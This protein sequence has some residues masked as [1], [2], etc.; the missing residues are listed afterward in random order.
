MPRSSANNPT[1]ESVCADLAKSALRFIKAKGRV[2]CGFEAVIQ[3]VDQSTIYRRRRALGIESLPNTRRPS[4]G[5]PATFHIPPQD[6][7][8]PTTTASQRHG[9]SVARLRQLRDKAGIPSDE[10]TF[11]CFAIE[12]AQYTP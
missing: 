10:Q 9:V 4:S 5:R 11:R 8:L 2:S 7:L 3:G 1:W 6:L 12:Q